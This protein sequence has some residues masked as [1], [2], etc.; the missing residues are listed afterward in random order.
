MHGETVK[1]KKN[2]VHQLVKIKKTDNFLI[3]SIS[4][5]CLNPLRIYYF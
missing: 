2:I 5:K 3:R 1:F 4:F